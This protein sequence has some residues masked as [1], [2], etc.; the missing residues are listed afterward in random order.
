[1]QSHTYTEVGER[2]FKATACVLPG[3]DPIK[4][5]KK[6]C[7]DDYGLVDHDGSFLA[8]L[9]DGHGVNGHLVARF[10]KDFMSDFFLKNTKKFEDSPKSAIE[11]M[12]ISCDTQ[13]KKDKLDT[14]LS[15]TTA[16]VL[17]MNSQGIH[18]GSVGDSRAILSTI[19]KSLNENKANSQTITYSNRFAREIEPNRK[20]QAIALTVDQKPNHSQELKRIQNAGGEVRRIADEFGNPLGPY[21]VWVKGKSTP[22]L[23]MSRSIGDKVAASIGVIPNPILNSFKIYNELDQFVVLASDG[24]WD[25]MENFEVVNFV[26]KFRYSASKE[27]SQAFPARVSNCTIARLLCEEARFRWFGI[28]ENEDVCVDDIS[29]VIIEMTGVDPDLGQVGIKIEERHAENIFN[30]LAVEGVV[31][32][33]RNKAARNDPTRGSM[34]DEDTPYLADALK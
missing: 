31:N 8:V 24:L 13:L 9:F 6:D 22:G 32:L 4:D 5:R 29:C 12:V 20:L 2:I 3:F 25:V 14:L 30:S 28:L 26:E 27:L 15:G 10:C 18:V 17:Y 34:A 23:G 16:V 1:M 11:E 19:P 33:N 7:Q 21:R